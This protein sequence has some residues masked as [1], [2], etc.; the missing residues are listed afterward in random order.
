MWPQDAQQLPLYPFRPER[1]LETLLLQLQ[2]D[3][4]FITKAELY[5]VEG[6]GSSATVTCR[7]ARSSVLRDILAQG[8]QLQ[9]NLVL[10]VNDGEFE[11]P[12]LLPEY[13]GKAFLWSYPERVE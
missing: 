4:P 11:V 6:I 12:I 7:W 1:S 3:N 9:N 10:K 2:E 13:K 8:F 5:M